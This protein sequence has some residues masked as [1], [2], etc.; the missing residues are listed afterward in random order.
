[1]TLSSWSK[2]LSLGAA[3]VLAVGALGACGDDNDSG[4]G[5]GAASGGSASTNASAGGDVL[6]E[7]KAAVEKAKSP[8]GTY[9]LP[10]KGPKAQKGKKVFVIACGLAAEACSQPADAVEEAGKTLSWDVTKVDG[11][12]SPAGY[13]AGVRQA[14][15]A[16]A[17]G[18]IV[19]A[20]DCPNAK[21]AYESAKKADIPIVGTY[22]Y[23]C[24]TPLVGGEKLFAASINSNGDPRE[25][26]LDNAALRANYAIAE[27]NAKAKVISLDQPEFIVAKYWTQGFADRLKK[28]TTCKMVDNVDFTANDLVSGSAPQKLQTVLLRHPDVDTLFVTSDALLQAVLPAI[29]RANKPNLRIIA[30]EGFPAT[31]QLIRRGT[32]DAAVGIYSPWM[33]WSG[34]DAMNRVFAGQTEIPNQGLGYHLITK[35]N[36]PPAGENWKPPLDYESA[37]KSIWTGGG[38][39]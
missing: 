21:G 4:G 33:G 14:I 24:D 27:S 3:T 30:N 12:F 6:A 28:C 23:D 19:V 26:A 35:E 34:A 7:A 31:Q 17:D 22:A 2:R 11:K 10:A 39:S 29:R 15:A 38:G 20:I 36:A 1:M 9:V 16:K 25:W 5:G 13:N 8:E 37:F 32:V 18:I